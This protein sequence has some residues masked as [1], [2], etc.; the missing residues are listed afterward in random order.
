MVIKMATEMDE[1]IR[2]YQSDI[3]MLYNK[4]MKLSYHL[5]AYRGNDFD[6]QRRRLIQLDERY[7]DTTYA[8]KLLIRSREGRNKIL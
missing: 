7:S 2:Q 3:S 5:G 6:V 8:L 4:R 1:L